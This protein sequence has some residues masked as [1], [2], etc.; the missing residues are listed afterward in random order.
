M[1]RDNDDA[2][3]A[4]QSPWRMMPDDVARATSNAGYRPESR[5]DVRCAVEAAVRLGIVQPVPAVSEQSL[6]EA[7]A[8]RVRLSRAVLDEKQTAR[9][10]VAR[11]LCAVFEDDGCTAC[12]PDHG[13][14]GWDQFL[15]GAD[16]AITAMAGARASQPLPILSDEEI[17]DR[18]ALL[19]PALVIPRNVYITGAKWARARIF[20]TETTSDG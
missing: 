12:D 13:C 3:A 15:R 8:E 16:A 17:H 19:Y 9:E 18:A 7:M 6:D 5:V 11:A 10:I 4:E 20:S 1:Q 14:E 2:K